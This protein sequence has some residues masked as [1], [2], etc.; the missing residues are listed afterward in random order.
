MTAPLHGD[1]ELVCLDMAG[2]TVA[3]NGVVDRAFEAALDALNVTEATEREAMGSYVHSTMGT[4]KIEVFRRLFSSEDRAQ[5]AN[6][7]FET[8]YDDA[9]R[10]G[11]VL[12][13]P[14]AAECLVRLRSAGMKL[15]L[16]T[17]F[18]VRTRDLVVATLGWESLVDLVLSP[19][20]AGRGRPYPDMILTAVLA[21]RA[22]SVS[23]VAVVGDTAA[24]MQSGRR[25]GASVVV[26][27]RSGADDE[28]RLSSYG[29]THVI[30]S[31]ADLVD[32]LGAD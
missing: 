15:A 13:L 28:A 4:S 2:T 25:A 17:G 26:G 31:V 19:S 7:A 23:Q 12:A 14:G 20:D 9:V 24:D 1:L 11:D 30:E 8:A 16:T 6:A 3:D 21:L 5:A 22:D 32:L 27:V 18:S 29:A 10:R